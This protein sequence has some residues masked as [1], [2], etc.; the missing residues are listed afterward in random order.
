MSLAT[1]VSGNNGTLLLTG[2]PS[3]DNQIVGVAGSDAVLTNV[4]FIITGA[5]QIGSGDGGLTL[6]NETAGTI[7]ATGLLIIDTGNQ[8]LSSGLMEA[9]AGG[10]LQIE[11]SVSNTGI[12][13]ATGADA[14]VT[15]ANAAFDNFGTISA[16]DQGAISFSGVTFTNESTGS[17]NATGGTI[18]VDGGTVSNAGRVSAGAGGTLTIEDATVTNS[19]SGEVSIGATSNLNLVT[20]AILGG[21]VLNAG[22]LSATGTSA[23]QGDTVTNTGDITVG[24]NASLTL[25]GSTSFNNAAGAQI[26]ANG[27]AITI[28]LDVNADVNDGTIEALDGGSVTIN[29]N[30]EGS[31]NHGLIEAVGDGSSVTFSQNNHEHAAED[32]DGDSDSGGN[33]E[34]ME[35]TG[36][37]VVTFNSGLDN[38]DLVEAATGGTVD[39]TD[40]DHNHSG[41]TIES[42]DTNSLSISAMAAWTIPT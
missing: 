3:G 40:D 38:Y 14:L 15:M 18:T 17:V 37:G 26:E 36:G 27:G 19:D 31:S 8:V 23:I 24:E 13:E 35:A 32:G 9:T 20:A 16:Q 4:D 10:T 1:G 42:T 2:T 21:T 7:N 41:G 25:E 29:I 28:N 22:H 12:V 33:Y 39:L 11:D 6:I 5:G 34:T 30:A